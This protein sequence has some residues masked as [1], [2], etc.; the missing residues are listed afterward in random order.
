MSLAKCSCRAELAGRHEHTR[1]AASSN[2]LHVRPARG[3]GAAGR[4]PASR[5]AFPHRDPVLRAQGRAQAALHQLAAGSAGQSSGAAGLPREDRSLRGRGR[6]GRRHDGDQSVRLLPRARRRAVAV[7][8]RSLA[9]RRDRAVPQGRAAGPL[10]VGMARQGRSQQAA[11]R[12]FHRRPERTPAEGH[13]L[14]RAPGA[15]RAELR[16]DAR[17]RQGLVPRQRLAS[18][19]HPAPSR[20]RRALR[21]GLPDPA[22]ARR[23]AARRTGRPDARL[24]RPPCLV[25]DLPAGRRLDRSRPDLGPADRRRPHPAR[26][27]ARAVECRAD[28]RR[29]RGERGRLLLRHEGDARARDAAHHQA[30]QRRAVGQASGRR[31]GDRERHRQARPA[32]HHGRRADLR[33]DRRH[34]RRGMEHAGAG[35]GEAAQGGR[36]VPQARRPLCHGAPAAFR[37]GQVVSRRAAAALVAQLPLAQG[38]RGDLARRPS[39]CRGGQADAAPRRRWRIALRWPSRSACSSIPATSSGP[40]KTPGT[41]CGA[42]GDCPATSRSTKPR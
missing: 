10:V 5:P 3:A 12:R 28:R 29:G 15:G 41:T 11:H 32:A 34:G 23:E 30:L 37:P 6:P 4:A 22:H 42:N 40:S 27:H 16:G 1:R 7:R 36:A 39:L 33:V 31:R 38:R 2:D 35:A 14:H 9:R 25:R 26:L 18:G 17:P 21:L 13:R 8:L 24:H 20:L 19:H